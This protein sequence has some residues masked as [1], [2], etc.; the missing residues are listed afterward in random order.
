M[1][2]KCPACKKVN[3]I[4]YICE[5]CGC[6]LSFL[7]EIF[8]ISLYELWLGVDKLKKGNGVEA[9]RHAKKSWHLKKNDDAAKL[10]FMACLLLRDFI[11]ASAWYHRLTK[12]QGR[13]IKI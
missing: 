8:D 1:E 11:D 12:L 13:G 7:R 6:D 10:A 4:S 9:L 3:S 5:R 2:I